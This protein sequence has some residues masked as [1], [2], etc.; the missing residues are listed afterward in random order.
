MIAFLN[1]PSA[2]IVSVAASQR[3][4]LLVLIL[5]SKVIRNAIQGL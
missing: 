5:K 2:T 1:L 3:V 4:R